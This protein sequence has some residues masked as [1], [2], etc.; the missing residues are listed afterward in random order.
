MQFAVDRGDAANQD[1][2]IARLAVR[3]LVATRDISLAQ[4]KDLIGDE[5]LIRVL[6]TGGKDP[7]N[8]ISDI[9]NEMLETMFHRGP[10]SFGTYI[11][12]HF[13]GGMRRL[14]INGVE[15]GDQPLFNQDK[16]LVM[17]YNGEIYN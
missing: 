7:K 2:A 10:D 3:Q 14:S 13:S 8:I 9:L 15:S 5:N 11:S 4:A 12:G 16:T 6:M 17:F 1:E